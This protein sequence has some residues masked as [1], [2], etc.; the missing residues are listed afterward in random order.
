MEVW[1]QKPAPPGKSLELSVQYLKVVIEPKDQLG[2]YMVFSQVRD[3]N[4]GTVLQL[5][6]P[7]VA[8]KGRE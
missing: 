4:S 7:F 8:V 1:D 5:N 6:A 3:N 2:K